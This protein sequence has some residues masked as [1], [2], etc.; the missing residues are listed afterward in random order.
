VLVSSGC[1]PQYDAETHLLSICPRVYGD[2]ENDGNYHHFISDWLISKPF[3]RSGL[4]AEEFRHAAMKYRRSYVDFLVCYMTAICE[5]QGKYRWVD[6]TP[7]HVFNLDQIIETIPNA[8]IIHMI[9][10]G[11]DVALSRSKL[12]WI[13]TRQ[14]DKWAR[15]LTAGLDWQRCVAAGRCFGIAHPDNY[16]ELR[17]EDLILDSEA[18]LQ[19]INHFLN[20]SLTLDDINESNF[21]SLGKGNTSTDNMSGLARSGLF[22]WRK[23]LSDDDLSKI[24]YLL[25]DTLIACGYAD[26]SEQVNIKNNVGYCS[27]ASIN[28]LR[29]KS[30]TKAVLKENSILSKLTR[31]SL[32]TVNA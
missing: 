6:Q 17:Y 2:I 31:D 11:R 14:K 27:R 22:R 21:G 15:L 10:D 13:S 1:F 29:M 26:Q 12:G 18:V 16:L 4:D 25:C 7:A 19:Q 20:I 23:E 32:P 8:K 3:S 28:W 24:N 9:R 30:W 5:Q